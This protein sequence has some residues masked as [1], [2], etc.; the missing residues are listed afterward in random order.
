MLFTYGQVIVYY[1]HM[2]N[3][4]NKCNSPFYDALPI[5][6]FRD[7]AGTCGLSSGCDLDVLDAHISGAKSV[8]EIGAGYGRV[9][10]HLVRKGFDGDIYAVERNEKLHQFLVSKFINA[11]N[12]NVL[13]VDLVDLEADRK[14]DLIL[15]MWASISEFSQA[16]QL[17]ILSN[18][19]SHLEDNGRIIL[20][21][22][23]ESREP[24]STTKLSKGNYVFDTEY[25]KDYGYFPTHDEIMGYATSLE[26]ADVSQISYKTDTDRDRLLYIFSKTIG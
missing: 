8:L 16:E 15:W 6:V 17:S 4:T 19:Y 13:N 7:I 23:P 2:N 9:I 11:A 1:I 18:L 5:D 26:V 24:N 3:W 20:D 22:V 12:V 25:G 14:F 21:A 10:D